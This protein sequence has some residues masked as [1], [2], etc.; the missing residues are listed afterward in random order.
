MAAPL[1]RNNF[2]TINLAETLTGW[3]RTTLGPYDG[4]GNALEGIGPAYVIQ[5]T[6]SWEWASNNRNVGAIYDN[7]TG[8][9]L[10]DSD[11]LYYWLF[12]GPGSGIEPILGSTGAGGS[13]SGDGGGTLFAGTGTGANI[14]YAVAGPET[15]GAGGRN[16]INYPIFYDNTISTDSDKLVTGSPGAAPSIFGG[17]VNFQSTAR[18]PNAAIDAIRRGNA[19]SVVDGG[20]S[21]PGT[22]QQINTYN[23]SDNGR[24]GLFT[25]VGGGFE[26]NGRLSIGETV[27]LVND[28]AY[29]VDPGASITIPENRHCKDDLSQLRL[30]GTANSKIE[31]T[32]LTYKSLS[33]TLNRGIFR[34]VNK[35]GDIDLVRCV[36][37][38]IQT[39]ELGNSTVATGSTWQNCSTVLQDSATITS[40]NFVSSRDTALLSNDPSRITGTSWTSSGTGHGIELTLPGTYTA[41]NWS[42]SGYFDSVGSNLN[43]ASGSTDSFLFNNTGGL[44]TIN[45]TGGTADFS[46]RNSTG[47]TTELVNASTVTVT[48]VLGLSEVKVLPTSGSPYSGNTLGTEIASTEN[49][50]ADTFVGDNTNY[51]SYTNSGGKVRITLNGSFLFTTKPGVLSDDAG[52][53]SSG[54]QVCVQVRDNDLNPSL[55]LADLFEVT[56]VSLADDFIDTDTDFAT[57]TSVFGTALDA[58]NSRTVAVERKDATFNFSTTTGN[59]YDILV[60]RIGSDPIL[61]TNQFASTGTLPIAQ[62]GDRNYRNP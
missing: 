19:I 1:I 25:G 9:T 3:A 40:C 30:A 45:L 28:S 26:L 38:N 49:I 42:T 32:S 18:G 51:V 46:V 12:V 48:G 44:V 6:N 33:S 47:S 53:L 27:S 7:G 20:E 34:C 15:Y 61:L 50:S 31:L 16:Y 60:F 58:A 21:Q 2:Q 36:F 35:T 24:Y 62:V 11:H 39:N 52:G 23:D 8:I 37:D 41:N 10:A 43:D 14:I 57:F 17:G 5:G 54:D 56:A 55:Q 4:G 59:E 22:F 29:F 13:Y